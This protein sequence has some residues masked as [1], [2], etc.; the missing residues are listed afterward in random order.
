MEKL[1]AIG[2]KIYTAIFNDEASVELEGT[3][4]PIKK[5]AS[6]DVR[7]VDFLGY[8]FIE[9]N[10]NKPSQWGQKA[11]DGHKIMWIIKDRRYLVRIDDGEHIELQKR[12]K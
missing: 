3:Q 7:Y 5:F 10:R 8:R 11:R 4:H 12:M 6:S 9:Q 2:K 1:E